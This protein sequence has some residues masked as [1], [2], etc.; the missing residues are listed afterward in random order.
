MKSYFKSIFFLGFLLVS[1]NAFGQQD[2]VVLYKRIKDLSLVKND[3]LLLVLPDSSFYHVTGKPLSYTASLIDQNSAVQLPSWITL[4]QNQLSFR[5]APYGIHSGVFKFALTASSGPSSVSDTFRIE[6]INDV[7]VVEKPFVGLV[8]SPGFKTLTFDPLNHFIDRGGDQ[9]TYTVTSSQTSVVSINVSPAAIALQEGS[10]GLSEISVKAMDSEGAEVTTKF[11]VF[12]RNLDEAFT[13]TTENT[14]SNGLI[15]SWT[16]SIHVENNNEIWV[17]TDNGL[18]I[19][20]PSNNTWTSQFKKGNRDSNKIRNIV[21]LADGNKL[22]FVERGFWLSNNQNYTYY[23]GKGSPYGQNV[24]PALGDFIQ[25]AV[26]DSNNK[27]WCAV[28]ID[29]KTRLIRLD[30]DTKTIEL[31]VPLINE[32]TNVSSIVLDNENTPWLVT[33]KGLAHYTTNGQLI[34]YTKQNGLH[35]DEVLQVAFYNGKIYAAEVGGLDVFDGFN[36]AFESNPGLNNIDILYFDQE[37]NLWTSG[38][39]QLFRY[40]EADGWRSAKLDFLGP[41]WAF[42]YP[43]DDIKIDELNRVWVASRWGLLNYP[44][45][46]SVFT[47][48]PTVYNTFDGLPANDVFRILKDDNGKLY[49]PTWINGLSI[50]DGT[51][52]TWVSETLPVESAIWLQNTTAAFIAK[53]GAIWLGGAGALSASFDSGKSWNSYLSYIYGYGNSRPDF[54]YHALNCSNVLAITEDASGNIW[55]AGVGPEPDSLGLSK[56]D[57]ERWSVLKQKDGLKSG[58]INQLYGDT[59]GNVWV[60]Y[61]ADSHQITRI[62]S[63]GKMTHYS[64]SG[65]G[66]V[67]GSGVVQFLQYQNGKIWMA[68]NTGIRI[69]YNDNWTTFSTQ[70]GLLSNGVTNMVKDGLGNIWISYDPNLSLGVSMYDGSK[71]QHFN[72]E[73][74]GLPSDQVNSLQVLI[75]SSGSTGGRTSASRTTAGKKPGALFLGTP[76]EGVIQIE[77]E[78]LLEKHNVVT[79]IKSLQEK[80]LQ[81][82]P[83]PA[84]NTITIDRQFS[85][86]NTR[87]TIYDLTGRTWYSADHTGEE[88]T[89]IF[90]GNLKPGVY[91]AQLKTTLGIQ[92]LRFIIR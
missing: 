61:G 58:F 63:D 11:S 48:K 8:L 1:L 49:F 41:N 67:S 85:D 6:V 86:G 59:L 79:G 53:N 80:S 83:N 73:N 36:F 19:Y 91:I 7:P 51:N 30:L 71:W 78:N 55:A 10:L 29:Y 75:T 15:D 28:W 24:I 81:L 34:F 87:I 50:Y 21:K 32:N 9:L 84:I 66:L 3:T 17:G 64:N 13:F 62:S 76:N 38:N 5:L 45:P 23:S 35:A 33:Q 92:H 42:G 56:F 90:I 88:Q 39:S 70:N 37:G 44:N 54:T 72:K 22:L 60:G 14:G 2:S 20:N 25:S 65:A 89:E 77:I 52:W 31:D 82:Y 40:N 26:V 57:G 18:T 46:G 4:F 69:F 16:R 74:G 12:I 47:S 68:T 43:V 27:L